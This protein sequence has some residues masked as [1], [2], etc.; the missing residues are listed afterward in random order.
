VNSATA[1][2]A[3]L[4]FTR[5]FEAPRELVFEC[6]TQPEHLTH[7][8]GPAGTNAPIEHIT[9]DARPGGSFETVMINDA[10]GSRYPTQAVFDEVVEPERL[11]WTETHSGMTVTVTF[12][13]L[14]GTRTGVEIRQVRV[15]EAFRTPEAQ[16][17]FL[18]SLDRFAGYLATLA[19]PGTG[20]AEGSR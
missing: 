14:G 9:V 18:T 7:F 12:T 15:P 5:V 6:M 4:V 19:A 3:E 20:G 16:A 2:P 8:W 10:D 1:G 11:V 17:G 13:D